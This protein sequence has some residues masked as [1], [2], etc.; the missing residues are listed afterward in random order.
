MRNRSKLVDRVYWAIH[1]KRDII[2]DIEYDIEND[3]IIYDEDKRVLK[4]QAIKLRKQLN[5]LRRLYVSIR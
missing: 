1:H 3:C 4:L 5:K 2:E